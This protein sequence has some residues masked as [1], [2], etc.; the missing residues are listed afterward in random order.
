MDARELTELIEGCVSGDASA[1]AQFLGEYY[2][3]AK[4]A[5][6]Q[7]HRQYGADASSVGEIDDICHELFVRI[8]AND[9]RALTRVINPASLDAWIVTAARNEAVSAF[10]KRVSRDRAMVEMAR[11]RP[12]AYVPTPSESAEEAER[13]ATIRQKLSALKPHDRLILDLY[14]LHGLKY[15]EISEMTGMNINTVSAR[16]RRARVR[17]REAI[18]NDWEGLRND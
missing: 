15:S 2:D 13:N 6:A 9:C 7:S 16:L 18:G 8:F 17:L 11:E 14:Y 3:L 10:R 1:R 12:T 5:T 4:R